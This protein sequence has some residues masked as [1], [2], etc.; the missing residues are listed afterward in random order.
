MLQPFSLWLILA[1]TIACSMKMRKLIAL[2][3]L[4]I[5]LKIFATQ[6]GFVILRLFYS[7]INLICLKK[8]I[9]KVPL[10]IIFPDYAG[11][12]NFEAGTFF[13]EQEFLKRN[14]YKKPIYCHVTCATD[15]RNVG[16]VF[17]GVKDIVVREALQKAGLVWELNGSDLQNLCKVYCS[18]SKF[19]VLGEPTFILFFRS[20]VRYHQR[21]IISCSIGYM[22]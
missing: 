7:L 6:D 18:R 9:K 13:L 19:C 17:N 16:V 22:L 12:N 15:T 14:H 21:T 11:D 5:Y 4:W 20:S 1:R 3:K 10:T 8:K 2:K